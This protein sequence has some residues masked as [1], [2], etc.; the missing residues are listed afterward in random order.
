MLAFGPQLQVSY[1]IYVISLSLVLYLRA[2]FNTAVILRLLTMTSTICALDL[3]FGETSWL[4]FASARNALIDNRSRF[5]CRSHNIPPE[6][7]LFTN[8]QRIVLTSYSLYIAEGENRRTKATKTAKWQR[9]SSSMSL[10]DQPTI[11][12]HTQPL[13]STHQHRYTS[14]P[15]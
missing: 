4:M 7:D 8:I 11:H 6:I 3:R 2:V 9:N 1:N 12:R 14:Q 10:P 15:H 5:L 13:T